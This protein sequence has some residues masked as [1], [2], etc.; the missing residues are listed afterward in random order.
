M[1][2][3]YSAIPDCGGLLKWLSVLAI[4]MSASKFFEPS[5]STAVI[6][7]HELGHA[8]FRSCGTSTC[9]CQLLCRKKVPHAFEGQTGLRRPSHFP[10]KHMVERELAVE[11]LEEVES[12]HADHPLAS[13]EGRKTLLRKT[14]VAH[15]Q[16]PR[17]GSLLL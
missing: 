2:A 11:G 13:S 7:K 4:G 1:N 10:V 17:P 15:E 12:V 5:L 6:R 3:Y 16:S 8:R 9:F 14:A